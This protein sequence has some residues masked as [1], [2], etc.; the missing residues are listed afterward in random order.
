MLLNKSQRNAK[1]GSLN[2]NGG[3]WGVGCGCL[4]LAVDFQ[5]SSTERLADHAGN[6]LAGKNNNFT[7]KVL[8]NIQAHDN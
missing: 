1:Y 5:A 3:G 7:L 8:E 2:S 6:R 4:C